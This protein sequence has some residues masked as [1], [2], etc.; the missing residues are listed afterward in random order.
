MNNNEACI[1]L[2]GVE[3][4]YKAN[5]PPAVDSLNLQVRTGEVLCLLGPS[6]SGKTTILRAINRMVPISAGRLLLRGHDISELD[7][8]KHRRSLGY[9]PQAAG[10]FP[11]MTVFQNL[12]IPL[13]L[14]GVDVGEWKERVQRTIAQ[15]ELGEELLP[16]WPRSLS[17]GQA[18]RVA[19]ARALVHGPDCVLMD[20]P[21]SAL[22]PLTRS[23]VQQQFVQLKGRIGSTVLIVTHDLAEAVL[24]GDRIALL[25]HGQLMQEGT[26]EEMN[27]APANEFVSN[28]MSGA[29]A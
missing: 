19:V 24:L 1:D 10:L 17:G 16:R 20:E 11:H 6:G 28:F 5:E 25:R 2:Q 8:Y 29:I 26:A 22:D 23:D 3:I 18:Q 7:T 21:F 4:R 12:C 27:E 14:A 15:V 9:V 13:R